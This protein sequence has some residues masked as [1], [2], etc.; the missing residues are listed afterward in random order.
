MFSLSVVRT[1]KASLS[2]MWVLFT[3]PSKRMT[4]H[5]VGIDVFHL[6]RI[7]V[8]LVVGEER[9][10]GARAELLARLEARGADEGDLVIGQAEMGGIAAARREAPR[11]V[12]GRVVDSGAQTTGPNASPT[13]QQ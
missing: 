6:G 1:S 11:I 9:E 5:Y 7:G 10:A 2:E 13:T 8:V 12:G 4:R 3:L